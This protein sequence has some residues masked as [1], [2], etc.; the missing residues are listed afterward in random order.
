MPTARNSR[1]QG[2]GEARGQRHRAGPAER[3]HRR[4]HGERLAQ[5]RDAATF[6][7]DA[8]PRR[9]LDAERGA[10]RRQ[11]E[12]LFGRLDVAGE[13]DGA[14]EV[15]LAGQRPQFHGDRAARK[16]AD[17]ELTEAT[18]KRQRH[19]GSSIIIPP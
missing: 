11:I 14:A 12:H 19:R 3:R 2:P 17:Q 7:I 9:R 6:L 5:T 1:G 18:A 13:E 4:P 10:L 16:A 8:H 15:E